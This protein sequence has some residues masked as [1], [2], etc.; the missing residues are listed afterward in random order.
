MK[1]NTRLPNSQAKE[2]WG[3]PLEILTDRA[4]SFE[5]VSLQK[6]LTEI[7]NGHARELDQQS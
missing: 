4:R 7:K 5:S 2:R 6:A 1:Q 3:L